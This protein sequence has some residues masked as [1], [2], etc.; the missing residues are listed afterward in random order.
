MRNGR[1]AHP[2]RLTVLDKTR[3]RNTA[4]V[5]AVVRAFTLHETLALALALGI[6]IREGDLH[7]RVDRLRAGICEE[8]MVQAFGRKLCHAARHFKRGRVTQ[9]ERRLV[10][11]RHQLLM[12]GISNFLT[13]VAGGNAEQT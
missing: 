4:E 2:K 11:E 5:D 6:V 9:V 13:A 10:V 1:H 7:C 8:D 3:E 12:H